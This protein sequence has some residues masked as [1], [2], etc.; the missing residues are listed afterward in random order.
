MPKRKLSQ[1][2][3]PQEEN[4]ET[5]TA[6]TTNSQKQDK[7]KV[8]TNPKKQESSDDETNNHSQ[9]TTVDSFAFALTSDSSD[10]QSLTSSS[11]KS[12]FLASNLFQPTSSNT[13]NTSVGTSGFFKLSETFKDSDEEEDIEELEET[14]MMTERDNAEETAKLMKDKSALQSLRF[15]KDPSTLPSEDFNPF[16]K[17]SKKHSFLFP[18]LPLQTAQIIV[19]KETQKLNRHTEN[20]ESYQQMLQDLSVHATIQNNFRDF[21]MYGQNFF[22]KNNT[23]AIKKIAHEK[24]SITRANKLRM[25]IQSIERRHKRPT[26]SKKQ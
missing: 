4:A 18:L 24:I 26:Q 1:Q 19:E 8:K 2:T 12:N 13:N 17:Y 25:L 15:V 22:R 16:A 21:G 9:T 6:S 20:N 11:S 7:K 14:P 3:H 5:Q 10:Q 23:E